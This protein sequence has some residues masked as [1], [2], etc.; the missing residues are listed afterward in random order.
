MITNKYWVF[1]SAISKEKCEEIIELGNKNLENATVGGEAEKHNNPDK[2]PSNTLTK[3]EIKEK[4]LSTYVRDSQ[5]SWIDEKW[6]YELISPFVQK[7]NDNAG[8]KFDIE[9]HETPQFTKY[10]GN[11]FY[12]WHTDGHGD[13]NAV[14]KPFVRGLTPI[15]MRKDGGVPHEYTQNYKQFY[16]VRKLSM[17]VNL[18]DP[19][20]Y[21]GGDL[22]F[23]FG[24]ND[25]GKITAK[26][27][28]EQGSVIVFPSFLYHCI[29]P[30]TRG[31]RYSLVNWTLGR[32][33]K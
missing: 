7:A 6:L 20:T 18:T 15:K 32:P 19:A 27:G 2:V 8:W 21:D 13:H 26:E 11:G 25:E 29:S 24:S 28:R 12:G 14:F 10:S 22:M 5:V 1:K 33:F 16:K 30:V 4:N 3:Q 23:D 17:T 31:I 9:H